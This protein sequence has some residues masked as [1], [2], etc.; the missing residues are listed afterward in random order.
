[1]DFK[2][3]NLLL[4]IIMELLFGLFVCNTILNYIDYSRYPETYMTRSAPWYCYGAYES[5]LLFIVISI[6]C[7]VIKFFMHHKEK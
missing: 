5:F 4:N 3:I 7:L 6:I 1:M 2:K